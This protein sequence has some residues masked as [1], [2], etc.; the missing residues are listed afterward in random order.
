MLTNSFNGADLIKRVSTLDVLPS[1]R[2]Q[3]V[4]K[5][6]FSDSNVIGVQVKVD[7]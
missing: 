3:R 7:E 2:T 4:H 6:F 5:V 1:V